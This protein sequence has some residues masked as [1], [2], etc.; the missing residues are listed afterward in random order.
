MLS[1]Q[2]KTST[3]EKLKSLGTE[4]HRAE[5]LIALKI[6]LKNAFLVLYGA[7]RFTSILT[8]APHGIISRAS[9]IHPF[10]TQYCIRFHFNI[11]AVR[12]V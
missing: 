2:P 1:A 11:I 8:T 5:L 4:L 10:S 9:R 12:Y 7:R 3:L 6:V